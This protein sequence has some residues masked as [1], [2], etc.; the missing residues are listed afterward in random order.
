MSQS[1]ERGLA[2][3]TSLAAGPQTLDQLAQ[4]LGVHKSTAMRLL[5]SLEA[6]RFVRREDVHHYRLGSALFDLAHQA[7]EDLDVR[8][9]ARAHL[10]ELNGISG[11]TVHLATLEDDHVIYIDKVDSKH[12]VRMYSRIGR[13]APVHCT[14]VGKALVADWPPAQRGQFAE[15]LAYPKLTANTI[16]SA[17]RFLAELDRVRDQG[18]AV[19]R[20]EHEDFIHCVAAPIRNHRGETIAAVSLSVPKVL[21]DFDGLL[22][23]VDDVLRAAGGVSAELGWQ[24]TDKRKET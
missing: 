8:D 15:Q 17:A 3:L 5:R 19:D 18:Y 16:D 23:L 14:A 2:V 22:G 20:S 1:L 9:V 10:L 6:G 24:P 21:L 12:P 4:R 11:H 7:L 13:R